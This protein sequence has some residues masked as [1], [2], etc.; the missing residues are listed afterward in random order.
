MLSSRLACGGEHPRPIGSQRDF[1]GPDGILWFKVDPEADHWFGMK[2]SA[3][4]PNG[5]SASRL[6]ATA[7]TQVEIEDCAFFYAT[8]QFSA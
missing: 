4:V 2:S 3:A 6:V 5:F 8:L 1:T 7:R